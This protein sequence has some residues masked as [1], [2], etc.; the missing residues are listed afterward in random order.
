MAVVPFAVAGVVL[1]TPG[2]ASADMWFV[3]G[4]LFVLVAAGAFVMI[5]DERRRARAAADAADTAADDAA[6]E[7]DPLVPR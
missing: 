6:H 2:F 3:M 1:G 4:V 5:R 7:P